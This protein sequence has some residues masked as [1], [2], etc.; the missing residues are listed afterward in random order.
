MKKMLDALSQNAE[1][2]QNGTIKN[3]EAEIKKF[4][5]V[6]DTSCENINHAA[7]EQSNLLTNVAG[8][9]QCVLATSARDIQSDFEK[10][11]TALQSIIKEAMEQIDA[12]YQENMKNMFKAMADNLAAITQQLKTA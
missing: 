2:L 6:I 4:I 3:F 5:Q 12:D 8:D 7:Q 9:V 1:T 10:T 11:R